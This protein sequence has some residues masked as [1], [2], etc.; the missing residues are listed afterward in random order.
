MKRLRRLNYR[1]RFW[2]MRNGYRAMSFKWAR[3]FSHWLCKGSPGGHV[4][5]MWI[6]MPLEQGPLRILPCMIC[7]AHI[8]RVHW[9]DPEFEDVARP[10]E[11][12]VG[13]VEMLKDK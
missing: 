13:V 4:E 7:G 5:G 10:Y 2:F 12:S 9:W 1:I 3:R 8:K 11:W 6:Q